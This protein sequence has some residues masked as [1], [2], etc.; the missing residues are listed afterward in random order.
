MPLLF[1]YKNDGAWLFY[2]FGLRGKDLIATNAGET[3]QAQQAFLVIGRPFCG[4]LHLGDM[5]AFD[6]HEIGVGIG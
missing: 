1:R 3:Q 2:S 6:Q 4:R 5:A